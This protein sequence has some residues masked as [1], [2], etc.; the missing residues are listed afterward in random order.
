[1]YQSVEKIGKNQTTGPHVDSE[2]FT[3]MILFINCRSKDTMWR[4]RHTIFCEP[5]SIVGCSELIVGPGLSFGKSP[6]R[7]LAQSQ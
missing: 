2:R 3:G 5:I 7:K 1:M 6:Y 4:S